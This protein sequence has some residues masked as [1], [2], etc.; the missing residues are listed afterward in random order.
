[1]KTGRLGYKENELTRICKSFEHESYQQ[2][3]IGEPTPPAPQSTFLNDPKHNSR[4]YSMMTDSFGRVIPTGGI[5]TVTQIKKGLDTCTLLVKRSMLTQSDEFQ[6]QPWRKC[7]INGRLEDL[8][9]IQEQNWQQYEN[10]SMDL[11]YPP[12]E[13]GVYPSIDF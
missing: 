10:H 11:E 6:T 1:V 13:K 9:K 2:A 7:E 3:L 4:G 5:C 12:D 8:L